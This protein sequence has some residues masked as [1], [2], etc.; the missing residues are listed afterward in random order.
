MTPSYP[1]LAQLRTELYVKGNIIARAGDFIM[2]LQA[3]KKHLGCVDFIFACGED[4]FIDAKN[5]IQ[6]SSVVS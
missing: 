6:C 2:V 1:Y 4:S 5:M 3:S